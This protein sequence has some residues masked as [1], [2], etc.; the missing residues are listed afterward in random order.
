MSETTAAGRRI[1]S[2][3][4]AN[5]FVEIGGCVTARNTDFNLSS[6]K[7][8][9]DGVITG[10]GTIDGRLAYIYSQDSSVLGGTV[11]EMHAKK[12]SRIYTLAA[13]CGAPVIG[14]IDCGGIRLEEA[15][16]ALD[17]LGRIFS[18]QALSSGLIPQITAVFGNCGGGLS[19]IPALSD[20]TFVE[21]GNGHLFVNTKD[22]LPATTKDEADNTS[23]EF[24]LKAGNAD[25]AGSEAE[26]CAEIRKLVGLLPQNNED[27]GEAEFIEDDLN[28]LTPGLASTIKDAAETLKILSDGGVFFEAKSGWA[29][30]MV[31]GFIRLGG[32]T[33]GAV[34]NRGSE[35]ALRPAGAEKAADFISFCDAFN[36]PVLTLANLSSLQ[37]CRRAEKRLPR[38]A[39]RLAYA[40]ANATVPKVT[41]VTGKAYGTPYILMGS[42]SLGADMVYAWP[43]AEIGT[44]D[45]KM[46]AK[47]LADGADA[48]TLKK[49]AEEY[50][51]LQQ[52]VASAAA[53]GLVD[54]VIEDAETRKYVIG[55]FEMLYTKREDR[56]D[57][58]HGTV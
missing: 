34:A 23:A 3:L 8:P 27:E 51:A 10:Y 49:T 6:A 12:I 45:A 58:K 42:K 15:S 37:A 29:Q 52:S 48:A 20:F 55:A 35:D 18:K 7:A 33:V 50:S 56:P 4:D 53:R 1:A 16:D 25:F 54:T 9:S 31:T 36:I 11:G 22:S 14:L 28:R 24:Q 5:S 57:R 40:Y 26:I 21:S 44:M 41:V 38:A 43:D 2:L 46:A 39:A 30:D 32:Y 19:L 17:S 13:R 47:I